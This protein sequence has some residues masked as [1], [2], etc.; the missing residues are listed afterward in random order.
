MNILKK[1]KRLIK[2]VIA[3]LLL[4]L[5]SQITYII[6]KNRISDDEKPMFAIRSK[7]LKDGG[8]AEYIGLGYQVILWNKLSE[9]GD[10]V[11]IGSEINRLTKFRD[12][13]DGPSVELEIKKR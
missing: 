3:I 11:G 9:K 2:L 13:N 4:I 1:Y 8:S 5:V 12:L 7:V 6:D 10:G